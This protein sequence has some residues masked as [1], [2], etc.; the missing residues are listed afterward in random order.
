[1]TEGLN[2][3]RYHL[4]MFEIDDT[5]AILL[6]LGGLSVT[7]TLGFLASNLRQHASKVHQG[8]I[9][10]APFGG[11]CQPYENLTLVP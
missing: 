8:L 11:L 10:S 5:T 3:Y 7:R 4:G 6:L 2:N 1:M 9:C